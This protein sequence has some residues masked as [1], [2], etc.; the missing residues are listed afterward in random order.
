MD[1]KR[2]LTR[3]LQA[4]AGVALAPAVLRASGSTP[5]GLQFSQA[6]LPYPYE[7]LEPH[8]DTLTMQ[9]HY[10]RHHAA[11]VKNANEALTA[12]AVPAT[13]AEQLFGTIGGVSTKLRNNAGGAWNHDLFWSSMAPGK[14]ADPT[15]TVGDAI[16]GAFGSFGKFKEVFA[17]AAMKRF[18]SGWA[19][20]VVHEGH[21]AIGSTPNQDNPLMDLSE[22][23][24]RP[25][26]GL[27]V[28]EHAY[29]LKYQNKRNE[30]VAAWWNLVNWDAVAGRMG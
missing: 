11:Y 2:F 10:G 27:D 28:W 25:L 6:P 15:G 7:A 8:I 26:L 4:A 21:L 16:N 9:I 13:T 3:S 22:L 5:G 18:G 23:K 29:Y 19:W 20:L 14:G 24:G 17:E 1:R 30:Y 12:E